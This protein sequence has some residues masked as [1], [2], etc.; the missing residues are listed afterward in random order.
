VGIGGD[1]VS[2]QENSDF[3]ST[4][5][6]TWG[7]HLEGGVFIKVPRLKFLM[8]NLYLKITKAIAQEETI[9]V[10]LGGLEFG[11]GLTFGFDL[12]KSWTL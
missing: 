12:W 7:Y 2:Y 9:E 10:D 8:L 3:H 1:I 11:L 5:G 4:S 6:S